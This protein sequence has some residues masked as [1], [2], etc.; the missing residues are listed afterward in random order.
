MKKNF[1]TH[2]PLQ[3]YKYLLFTRVWNKR[4]KENGFPLTDSRFILDIGKKFFP[5]KVRRSWQR[6]PREAVVAPQSLEC[7]RSEWTGLGKTW[8]HGRCPSPW[9]EV[10]LD[11]FSGSF[12]PKPFWDSVNQRLQK[13]LP[14]IKF[15]LS[16]ER[17]FQRSWVFLKLWMF[18]LSS[19]AKKSYCTP[20][21]W[22]LQTKQQQSIPSSPQLPAPK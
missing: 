20:W 17:K 14:S 6:L 13:D 11:E 18:K 8:H 15:L 4:R 5:G 9:Q 16:L 7:P 22:H 21:T 1:K 2:S 10:E 19:A 12:Q 3:F